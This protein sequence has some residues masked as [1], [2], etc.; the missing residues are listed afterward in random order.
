MLPI[1]LP[2]HRTQFRLQRLILLDVL[3]T[4]N[5]NLDQHHFII[6]LGMIIQKHVE[7]FQLM[8]QT[9]DIVQP[10]NAQYH[11]DPTVLLLQLGNS[12]LHFRFAQRIVEFQRIDSDDEFVCADESVLVLN[13][14]GDPNPRVSVSSALSSLPGSN[15]QETS[16]SVTKIRLILLSMKT[17]QITRQNPLNQILANRKIPPE[18]SRRE[19][20][21]Q[22]K[23][24]RALFTLLQ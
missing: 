18:V 4:R 21:M 5:S 7:R 16:T 9:F 13:L 19:R 2:S 22:T 23:S 24:Y 17:N 6:Q 14:P 1:N 8:R 10:V 11:F 3:P 20:R 12:R 15:S